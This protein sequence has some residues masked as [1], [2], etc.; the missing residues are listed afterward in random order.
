MEKREREKKNERERKD[1][2]IE[3]VREGEGRRETVSKSS[4]SKLGDF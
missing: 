4:P 1:R 2:G 3:R